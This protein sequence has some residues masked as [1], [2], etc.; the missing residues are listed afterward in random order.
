MRY[1][2]ARAGLLGLLTNLTLAF[3]FVPVLTGPGV[4]NQRSGSRCGP[5]LP[6]VYTSSGR[7]AGQAATEKDANGPVSQEEMFDWLAAN[8]GIRTKTVSLGATS[9]GYRGLVATED[10]QE[11]Q[12]RSNAYTQQTAAVDYNMS[13]TAPSTSI[14]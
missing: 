4:I 2:E 6:K 9:G 8:A 11:G 13:A 5:A 10:V 3:S 12:V 7:S 1:S 14:S